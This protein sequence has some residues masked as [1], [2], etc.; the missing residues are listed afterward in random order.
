MS[1]LIQNSNRNTII[2]MTRARQSRIC[3]WISNPRL[4]FQSVVRINVFQAG[5]EYVTYQI[6]PVMVGHATEKAISTIY[7]PFLTSGK[8]E[9]LSKLLPRTLLTSQNMMQS[10]HLHLRKTIK[11]Q[12]RSKQVWVGTTESPGGTDSKDEMHAGCLLI[13]SYSQ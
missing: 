1:R 3:C 12:S 11:I 9:R 13:K 6:M 10:N 5:W 7:M 2:L 4:Q 8:T